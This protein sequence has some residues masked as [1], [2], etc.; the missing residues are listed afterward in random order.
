MT[1]VRAA[2]ERANGGYAN[3]GTARGRLGGE[4]LCA[5]LDGVESACEVC[6]E[7]LVPEIW[8]YPA[9]ASTLV[10]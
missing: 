6:G 3:D 4:L 10:I 8:C 1:L 7:S 5:C 2:Y 9:S